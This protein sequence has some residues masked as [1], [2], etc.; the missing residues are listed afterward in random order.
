MNDKY[1]MDGHKLYWHLDRVKDWLDGKRIA[2]LHIDAGL[3]KGCNI[4]CHYCFG[5]MQGNDYKKGLS[6]YFPRE[7]LLNY[8]R[9]AGK[10]GVRSI[11][12]I[13]EAEPTLNPNLYDAIVVGKKSGIDIALGTNGILLDIGKDGEKAIEHLT[14]IRFNL[15]AASDEAYRKL[16]GSTEFS[17]VLDR[18]RF[19]VH[20]KTSKKLNLTIGLQMVLTPQD[21]DQVLPL[22]KLGK[23]LGVD[24]LVIKQC[25]DS[26]DSTLGIYE[27][28]GEYGKFSDI[29]KEAE[30]LNDD[31]YHVI[32][33]WKKITGQ[34]K[35]DYDTCIG[36]PFVFYTSGD[37]KVF[38]CGM[39]FDKKWWGEYLIG[40]L[41]KQS[42]TEI[43]NSD[44]Y[45]EVIEK[46][47]KID[48]HTFCYSGCRTD[49]VNSFAWKLKHPPQ[50]V[51][52]I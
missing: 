12:F 38:S 32:A 3:S 1:L 39:F 25:S 24:Y 6:T 23:E 20:H 40:D 41:T 44:R 14:W 52:F 18:I 19:C 49:A 15:S 30:A 7:P 45:R 31:Q 8:M 34:G 35:R 28:L 16:H 5:A 36:A 13:G 50:H 27:K 2:P 29:L 42:F 33:K 21:A 51:N 43:I 26:Q 11:S 10:A 46:V 22:A 4:K 47:A 17:T 48:C 37:A 9:D